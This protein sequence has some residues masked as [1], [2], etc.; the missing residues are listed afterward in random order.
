MDMVRVVSATEESARDDNF[1]RGRSVS[2][3]PIVGFILLMF[4]GFFGFKHLNI[5]DLPD[6]DFPRSPLR[7][8]CRVPLRRSWR[9][10]PQ[11]KTPLRTPSAHRTHHIDRN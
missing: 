11:S 2:R 5:T 4:A 7:R 10:S 3:S 8:F 1:A 6:M 9:Q